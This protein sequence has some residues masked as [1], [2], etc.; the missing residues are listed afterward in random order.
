MSPRQNVHIDFVNM[1]AMITKKKA[2]SEF[3]VSNGR[4][5]FGL[6]LVFGF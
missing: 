1:M 6:V 4:K 2:T 3:W 5:V